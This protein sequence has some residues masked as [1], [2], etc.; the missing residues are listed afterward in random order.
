LGEKNLIKRSGKREHKKLQ[1]RNS[2]G[3]LEE[4][5]IE[6]G[7][8][9]LSS[10]EFEYHRS[11][12]KYGIDIDSAPGHEVVELELT[13]IGMKL[14]I[15][16]FNKM[17]NLVHTG[18]SK[19]IPMHKFMIFDHYEIYMPQSFFKE[20]LEDLACSLEIGEQ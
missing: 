5:N 19:T 1:I 17:L 2:G 13:D 16:V 14:M 3:W 11:T 8:I 20:C 7:V 4:G 12:H 6:K 18:K 10:I 15:S 9:N